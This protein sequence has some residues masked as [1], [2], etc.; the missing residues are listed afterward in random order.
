MS[1]LGSK[2]WCPNGPLEPSFDTI[3]WCSEVT[4]LLVEQPATVIDGKILC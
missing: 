3:A 2:S 1:E 4:F